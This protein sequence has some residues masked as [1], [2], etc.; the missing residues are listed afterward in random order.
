MRYGGNGK[1]P[2]RQ[3]IGLHN[4]EAGMQFEEIIKAANEFYSENGIAEIDKTPEPMKALYPID[5]GR[6]VA[7]Y[8]KKAQPDFKGTIR[9]GR[10][11]C[12]EAKHTE[13][14]DIK[15]NVVT[16]TQ[17]NILDRQEKM[18]AMCFVVVSFGFF[19]FYRIPWD[20]WKNMKTIYGRKFISPE[21]AE[22]YR[23]KFRYGILDYLGKAK[24]EERKDE[25]I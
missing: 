15:Q 10:G 6:F 21:D 5:K 24:L 18:G 16:D 2:I 13:S 20:V 14:K 25:S 3:I 8:V 22:P 17:A 9:G 19:A 7:C 23:I 12:F 1:K 4:R 11:V